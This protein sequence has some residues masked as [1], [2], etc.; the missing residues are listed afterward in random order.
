MNLMFLKNFYQ[1]YNLGENLI[2]LFA[3]PHFRNLLL[4][5]VLKISSFEA[6][7]IRNIKFSMVIFVS[8]D[9]LLKGFVRNTVADTRRAHMSHK[10]QIKHFARISRLQT[11]QTSRTNI[12]V[13]I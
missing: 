8:F 1:V 7:L 13:K 4:E 3:Q 5:Y 11:K 10:T 9:S 12:L 2:I 6:S